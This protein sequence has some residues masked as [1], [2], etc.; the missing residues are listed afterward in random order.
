MPDRASTPSMLQHTLSPSPPP[1]LLRVRLETQFFPSFARFERKRSSFSAGYRTGF[2]FLV[3]SYVLGHIAHI[4][5][6]IFPLLFL[7][8]GQR[9]V[10]RFSPIRKNGRRPFPLLNISALWKPFFFI[11]VKNVHP[12]VERPHPFAKRYRPPP[13]ESAD[14]IFDWELE[15][16]SSPAEGLLSLSPRR[17]CSVKFSPPPFSARW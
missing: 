14:S 15:N 10:R 3:F 7:H 12:G 16:V 9:A 11:H 2:V 6:A 13:V 5:P 17:R 4:D 1:P 8:S